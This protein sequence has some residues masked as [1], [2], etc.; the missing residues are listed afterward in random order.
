[1]SLPGVN[2]NG[3]VDYPKTVREAVTPLPY[4]GGGSVTL[5]AD[6]VNDVIVVSDLRRFENSN[7]VVIGSHTGSNNDANLQDDNAS[8][9]DSGIQVKDH[10]V[11]ISATPETTEVI[12]AVL[13][14]TSLSTVEG[15][16]WFADDVYVIN[17]RRS[18]ANDRA[19][20][21]RKFSI[22]TDGDVYIRIDGDPDATRGFD[23]ELLADETY[24]AENIRVA[25]RLAVIPITSGATPK[26]RWTAWGI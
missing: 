11:N 18:L 8:F 20:E 22:T 26:V 3:E 17:K 6:V 12:S 24:Y 1:M 15:L 2:S 4:H 21:I 16:D 23:I 10:V 19:I 5:T 13:S 7:A 25:A 14:E 9:I